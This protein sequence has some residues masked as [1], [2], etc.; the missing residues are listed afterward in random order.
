ML[1]VATYNIHRAVGA[2]GRFQPERTARVVLSLDADLVALQEVEMPALP[3]TQLLLSWFAAAGYRSLLGP[4]IGNERHGYGNVLLSRLPLLG[5]DR[6]DLSV[7]G[8]EPRGLVD[9][10]FG[11]LPVAMDAVDIG[12]GKGRRPPPH[13]RCLATHLGLSRGERRQQIARIAALLDAATSSGLDRDAD[14][15]LDPAQPTQPVACCLAPTLLLGDFNEWLPSR[16]LCPLD[17]RLRRAHTAAT[18][19]ARWPLLALD[20]LWYSGLRLHHSRVRRDRPARLASDH[21]PLLA[22][23]EFLPL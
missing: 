12:L 5:C 16:R 21:L 10:R 2:D 9:A 11:P 23:F 18:W 17:R 3:S 19:H 8:R 4:T 7:T 22:Q 15:D 20:R 14:R 6:V 1:R 13:L